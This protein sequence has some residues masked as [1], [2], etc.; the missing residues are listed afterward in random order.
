MLDGIGG[1][2][3]YGMNDNADTTMANGCLPMGLSHGCR[4]KQDLPMDHVL[5]YDDVEMPTPR[6][7]DRLRAEQDEL[8]F[9][10]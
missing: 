4:V 2:C 7:A 6:L 1:F 5:T 3:T 8:V 9:R 10:R